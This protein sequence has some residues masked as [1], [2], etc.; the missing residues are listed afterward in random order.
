MSQPTLY[1]ML[2]YPGSGKT[3]AS[4]AIAKVA[5]AVHL[6][7]D[8]ERRLKFK[9]PTYGHQENLRLYDDLNHKTKVLLTEGK[10]VV[11]DTNFNFY[12]DRQHLRKIAKDC[13]AE[14]KLIWVKTDK[15]IAKQRATEDA[16]L[17]ETR[18]LGNMPPEE[19]DRMS[20]N[21]EKPRGGE[22]YIELDG[23]KITKSYVAD[24]LDIVV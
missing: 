23:T 24:K 2:G 1:L 6:W 15:K 11:F 18:V 4:K 12:K 22:K 21:M 5:H 16:H 8:H 13:G 19:F 14:T 7:A 20:G 17:Q 3:T 10:S 9:A